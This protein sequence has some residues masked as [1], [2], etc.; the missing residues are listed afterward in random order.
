MHLEGHL[1]LCINM[2]KARCDKL[3]LKEKNKSH[4]CKSH[5]QSATINRLVEEYDDQRDM[6][7]CCCYKKQHTN[8]DKCKINAFILLIILVSI[9]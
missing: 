1:T 8:C 4:R 3:T 5:S 6:S 7:A 2:A 9:E